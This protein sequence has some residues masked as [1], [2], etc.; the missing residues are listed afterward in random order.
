MQ[1]REALISQSPSLELQRAAANEIARLDARVKFL[2]EGYYR[3]SAHAASINARINAA[4]ERDN[5]MRDQERHPDGEDYEI[6]YRT[7]NEIHKVLH[8]N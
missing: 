6:L 3:V 1:L 7:I 5:Q 4:M 8:G 2:T